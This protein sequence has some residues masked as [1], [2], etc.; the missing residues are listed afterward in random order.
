[1][2]GLSTAYHTRLTG[3]NIEEIA[4]TTNPEVRGKLLDTCQKLLLSGDCINPFHWIVENHIKAFDQEP[5][6]YSWKGVKVSNLEIAKEIAERLF[7][8]D[9]LAEQSR[10]SAKESKQAFED[11]FLSARTCFE[12]IFANGTERPNTFA[13][14]VKSFQRPGGVFWTGYA[15][16]FYARCVS[17]EPE[18][19]KV[20]DFADRCPPFLLM[21]IAAVKALYE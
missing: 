15:H 10:Q 16:K 4:A 8:D 13:E 9:K 20:R 19:S 18:K 14:L 3:S 17:T 5:K 1:L 6:G 12:K 21:I 11:I 2:A 7:F